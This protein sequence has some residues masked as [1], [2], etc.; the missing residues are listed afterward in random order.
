[1]ACGAIS[2]LLPTP[3]LLLSGTQMVKKENIF[4]QGQYYESFMN[5]WL[6]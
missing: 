6:G 1:M 2:S 3:Y 4:Q 5:A